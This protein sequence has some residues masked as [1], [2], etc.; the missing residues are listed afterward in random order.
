MVR[1]SVRFLAPICIAAVAVGVY[2]IVHTNVATTHSTPTSQTTGTVATHTRH[3]RRAAS[4]KPAYYTVRSGDTLSAIA[5]RTGVSLGRLTAL[6]HSL[7]P[8]YNLQTGQRLRLR[9]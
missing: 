9:R 3:R 1:N 2:L 4:S 5:G 6:N 7:S 8:P